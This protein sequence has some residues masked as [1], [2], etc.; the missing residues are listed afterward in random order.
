MSITRM[1]AAIAAI[2]ALAA[3]A[4]PGNVPGDKSVDRGFNAHS[5]ST[6]RA[7]I[8]VDPNGCHHWIIDDGLEGY[9]DA[10][11]DPYGKPVCI[12]TAGPPSTANGP[13]KEGSPIPD[14]ARDR[15]NLPVGA[16]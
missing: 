9:M 8:W 10:R 14:P 16:L 2:G 13:F 11:L 6:L 3:C 5:L 15:N 12:D 1:T 7:G 4:H